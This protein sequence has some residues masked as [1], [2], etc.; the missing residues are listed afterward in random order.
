MKFFRNISVRSRL[1]FALLCV[2]V[3]PAVF[4]GAYAYRSH[5]ISVTEKLA[6]S[7]EETIRL[8]DG[9][10]TTEIGRYGL[11]I[12]RISVAD[13]VQAA[14]TEP[15]ED[16]VLRQAIDNMILRGGHL[17]SFCVVDN[18]GMRLYDS[19]FTQFTEPVLDSLLR[20]ADTASPHDSLYRVSESRSGNLSIA[21]KIFYFPEGTEPIGYIVVFIHD[22]LVREVFRE[23]SFGGGAMALVSPDGTVLAGDSLQAGSS[24]KDTELYNGLMKAGLEGNNSFAAEADGIP[25]LI[26][27]HYNSRYDTYL[28]AAIPLSYINKDAWQTGRSMAIFTLLLALLCMVF[29]LLIYRSIERRK[30]EL[31]L[32]ALQYQISPHFL[33]NT[34][35][36]L[37]WA[38]VINDAPSIISEGITSLSK[39]LQSVLLG[40]NDLIPLSEELDNLS[41]Y[42]TIQNIRYADC[43]EVEH[44]VDETLLDHLVPRFVLQP[45]A[46]NAVLH[47]SKGGERKIIVTVRC[48]R[49]ANDLL[50]EIEDNG[51]GFDLDNV[52]K[53]Q[54]FG[55]GLPN[56]DERLRLYY[57]SGHGLKID[58]SPGKGTTCSIRIPNLVRGKEGKHD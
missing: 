41:H 32:R 39:L 24:L 21:R 28:L 57:G 8:L 23:V 51:S 17:R 35:S 37:K 18:H 2:S 25:S 52:P 11:V 13:E 14:L 3:I 6:E 12:D 50:L 48:Q 55:I 33:F 27:F 49:I 53:P 38:A 29:A 16:A 34:L 1:L 26:V 20:R 47:G 54:F 4:V 56:V 15:H 22:D 43:V 36:T 58:S 42:F 44:D 10:L 30:H 7:A 5:T 9:K 19:G 45:L 46:E 31:E 40:K